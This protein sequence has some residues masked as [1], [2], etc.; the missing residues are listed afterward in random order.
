M[1]LRWLA[2]VPVND[3]FNLSH[4]DDTES[5]GTVN[6]YDWAVLADNWLGSSLLQQE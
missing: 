5:Y 4:L 2:E 1:A 3:P 6:F